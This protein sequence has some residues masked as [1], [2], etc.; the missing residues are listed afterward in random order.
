LV[1]LINTTYLAQA[2]DL[3]SV[4]HSVRYGLG[5]LDHPV[6]FPGPWPG[7]RAV[8]TGDVVRTSRLPDRRYIWRQAVMEAEPKDEICIGREEMARVEEQLD[9]YQLEGQRIDRSAAATWLVS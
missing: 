9:S 6:Q 7:L 1:D 2:L 5:E 3:G 4:N 8:A